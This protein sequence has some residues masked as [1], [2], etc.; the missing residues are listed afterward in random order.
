MVASVLRFCLA[1]LLPATISRAADATNS[2]APA[3]LQKSPADIEGSPEWVKKMLQQNNPEALVNWGLKFLD[4]KGVP[5][6]N[7]KAVSLFYS[8]AAWGDPRAVDCLGVAFSSGNGLPKDGLKALDWF[9]AAAWEDY[10]GA[11]SHL[12]RSLWSGQDGI[13]DFN[14]AFKWNAR[15][16][17]HGYWVAE[18]DLGAMYEEGIGVKRDLVESL[19]WLQL[20]VDAGFKE[21]IPRRDEV[22]SLMDPTQ[23]A[24]AKTKTQSFSPDT[25]YTIVA[26][27]AKAV[28][29]PLGNIFQIPV[30][31]FDQTNFMI[32]DTG[33]SHTMFDI[34]FRNRLGKP[35]TSMPAITV[36]SS[37]TSLEVFE[38]P[39]IFIEKRGLTPLLACVED[40]EKIRQAS[41]EPF[42]GVI[43]MNCLRY[44]VVCFDSDNQVFSIGGSVPDRVKK[45]ALILPLT[46][47]TG[48]ELGIEA[49]ING[50]GPIFLALD[51]GDGSSIDLNEAD[52]KTV[53]ADRPPRFQ[54]K[55]SVDIEGHLTEKHFARVENLNLGTHTYKN[56]IASRLVN[57]EATSRLGQEFIERHECYID[58]P[59]QMLYLLPGRDFNRSEEYDMSGLELVRIDGKM[60]VRLSYKYSPAYQAGIRANDQIISINGQDAASLPLKTTY[61]TLK[62][63]PGNVIKMQIKHGDQTNSVTFR[64]KRLL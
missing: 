60:T 1:L 34:G 2:P 49:Y 43:G 52:W 57:P 59:N 21:A 38:C 32:V 35:V 18:V 11:Q 42:L 23:K 44:E 22:T 30:G 15:A 6:D 16:A 12:G 36:F 26:N 53:F 3:S 17:E 56:L 10:P 33:S 55:N 14:R 8:A 7:K 20:A 47:K 41:G 27:E 54:R 25:N 40:F 13:K 5:Q 64:L 37:A 31:I 45:S 62:A 50:R 24:E 61:E 63:K 9:E 28:S 19:K 39:K 58:F 51:S 46:A 29:C 48:R 4:G